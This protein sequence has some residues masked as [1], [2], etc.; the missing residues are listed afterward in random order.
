MKERLV[1]E[2]ICKTITNPRPRRDIY[3]YDMDSVNEAL[4]NAIIHNDYRITDPQVS[5]FDDRLEIVSHGGLPFG[6]SKEQFFE[7]VS[8]PRNEQLMDIFKRL[9]IVEHT[10]HGIPTIIK[11]Y[12]K[13]V[14]DIN[15]NLIRVTIPFNK[16]VLKNHGVISGAISGVV[17]EEGS[18]SI[19]EQRILDALKI[20]S[21]LTTKELSEIL[22]IPFR[23]VQRYVAHLRLDNYIVRKGSNKTGY[24]EVLK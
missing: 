9:G 2:N 19:E 10:G 7:G 13:D 22:S 18:L 6:L 11:I 16:E 3:L 8:K 1:L 21:Q 17:N 23:S 5:F 20:N 4:V 15:D 14:F 24:W 12:G